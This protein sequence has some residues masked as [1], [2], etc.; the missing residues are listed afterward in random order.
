MDVSNVKAWDKWDRVMKDVEMIDLN[1][2]RAFLDGEWVPFNQLE[3]VYMVSSIVD[4]VTGQVAFEGDIL[5]T[6]LGLAYIDSDRE[7]TFVELLDGSRVDVS[8]LDMT[9]IRILCNLYED[10]M[11]FD[12]Q[13]GREPRWLRMVP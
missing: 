7:G 3:I 8:N 4:D 9:S 1:G 2:R 11:F 13:W 12:E 5:N 10:P 6:R